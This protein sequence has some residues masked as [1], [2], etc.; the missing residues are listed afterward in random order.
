ML[1]TRTD[2]LEIGVIVHTGITK[3]LIEAG[4]TVRDDNI[5]WRAHSTDTKRLSWARRRRRDVAVPIS[6]R[7]VV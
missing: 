4:A 7:S 2:G 1:N 6:G 3:C 5:T